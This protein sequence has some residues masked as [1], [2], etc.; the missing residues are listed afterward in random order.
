MV[1][2]EGRIRDIILDYFTAHE[3][4][5]DVARDGVE[6]LEYI[7]IKEYDVMILDVLMPRLDGFGLCKEIRKKSKVPI[8]FLTAL[9]S[10]EDTLKGYA[11]GGDDYVTKPF[12]LAVL[13]AKT[14][15]LIRRGHGEN[16]SGVLTC[17]AISVDTRRHL[18]KVLG[19]EVK[20]SPREYELLVC[21]MRN[22][23]QVMSREQL[24]DKVW[25]LDFQGE[26]RAVDVRIRSLRFTLGSAG[27]QIKTMY[28]MGY[29][30]EEES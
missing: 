23:G 20:L 28:R 11:L 26:D 2:D 17:G 19:E 10:E 13:L 29:K 7:R 4:T 21:F 8:L 24:L 12:S 14:R 30:L 25:G 27:G 16:P 15:A 6:A 5:C 18:C 9:G 3:M 22:K 1:E